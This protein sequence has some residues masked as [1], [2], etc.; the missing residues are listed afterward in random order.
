MFGVELH[1][2]LKTKQSN[3]IS[4]LAHPGYTATNLQNNMGIQ[5]KI[6]NFLFAQKLQM[7]ILPTLRAATAPNVKGGEYYGPERMRNFRGYPVLNEL[8]P[9]A[10]DSS[11]NQRLWKVSED[12][13]QVNF[14]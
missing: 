9:V 10:L 7:G 12:L 4:V 14:N 3:T 6:M 11:L 13:I 2:R 1:Q 8:N 5:G